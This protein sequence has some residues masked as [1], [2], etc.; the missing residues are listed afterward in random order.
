MMYEGMY[1][2][3]I[4]VNTRHCHIF[5]ENREKVEDI[6]DSAKI[7]FYSCFDVT[8]QEHTICIRTDD[9]NQTLNLVYTKA[10]RF[11][12]MLFVHGNFEACIGGCITA[13][14]A[15]QQFSR[16]EYHDNPCVF[17]M[18]MMKYRDDQGKLTAK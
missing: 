5:F 18:S 13:T 4:F 9:D 15:A 14:L 16:L 7:N 12:K 3:M 10:G 1:D 6:L 11:K 8:T 2:K 17:P